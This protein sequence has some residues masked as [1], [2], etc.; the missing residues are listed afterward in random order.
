MQKER[1]N[2]MFK[3]KYE[4]TNLGLKKFENKMFEDENYN[5][6]SLENI[7]NTAKCILEDNP[8]M[9]YKE[10][11]PI[12]SYIKIFTDY[13]VNQQ[14]IHILRNGRD[15][16]EVNKGEYFDV[17]DAYYNSLEYI[18]LDKFHDKVVR[19][20][21][22][23]IQISNARDPIITK[24]WN[25]E[26][27]AGAV[28]NIGKGMMNK[29]FYKSGIE[30]SND[31]K[32]IETN[33]MSQYFYPLGI[34]LVYNG[35]HSIYS[36]MN[37]GEGHID[38]KEVYDMSYLYDEFYFDGTYIN[39]LKTKEKHKVYFEIGVLFEI[40]RLLLNNPQVF[41]EDIKRAIKINE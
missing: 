32:F 20:K 25:S 33:H 41:N 1:G 17:V 21:D 35:N 37:K 12:F 3:T 22:N 24:I 38:V 13:M 26:R 11:H 40:G 15:K 4:T 28:K 16:V 19:C 34:T 39:N 10:Q 30:K 2:G 31:F 7:I 27:I 29:H 6:T 9:V 18:L 36:G 5:K 14:A 8:S 23:V